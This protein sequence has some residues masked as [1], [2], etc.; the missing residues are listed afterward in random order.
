MVV[1]R[2]MEVQQKK[3]TMSF[4]QLDGVLRTVDKDGNRQSLSHKCSELDRQIPLLLGVSKSIL[5]HVVFC[6]QE[7]S[8][9]PLQEGAV[10]KKRFDDIFDSTRYSKAL[11]VFAKLKKE[12]N[13]KAKDLKADVASFGSHRHAA[14]GFRQEIEKYNCQLEELEDQI[15][16][17]KQAIKENEEE[18]ERIKAII[19]KCEDINND[20]ESR[21]NDLTL[22]QQLIKRQKT[23]LI[24]DLTKEKTAR[25]LQE[26]L[27]DFD[28][29]TNI[30]DEKKGELEAEI[31]N[32][33]NELSRLRKQE[34]DLQSKLV[35]LQAGK[36]SHQK[37]LKVRFEKMMDIGQNYGLGDVLTPISQ[38]Q[39]SQ[40]Q[41]TSCPGS[42]LADLSM[43]S[44]EQQPIL[45][46]SKEDMDEFYRALDKRERELKEAID[47]EREKRQRQEDEITD[48]ITDLNGKVRSMEKDSSKM[49]KEVIACRAEL[50]TI[51][52][53]TTVANR[54]RKADVEEAR[55]TAEKF[56]KEREIINSDPRRT[57]I[58][59]KLRSCEQKIDLLKREI[60]DDEM[61][62]KDLR[63]SA[64]SQNSVAVL[65]EQCTKDFE[66]LQESIQEQQ[67]NFNKFNISVPRELP[68]VLGDEDGAEL[69]EAVGKI[70]NDVTSKF[71][72]SKLELGS[73][74]G[75]VALLQN[76]LSESSA[77]LSH[78]RRALY[79]KRARMGQLDG[80]N[81]GISEIRSVSSNLRKYEATLGITT[82]HTIDE[83]RPQ[84]LSTYLSKRLAEEEAKST[85]GIEPETVRK[86]LTRLKSQTKQ[87]GKKVACPCC[88]REFASEPEIVAFQN[89]MKFLLAA[90]SPLLKLDERNKSARLNYKQWQQIVAN[91]INDIFEYQRITNEVD[92][93]EKN[94]EKLED[95]LSTTK[96]ELDA[97]KGA[98]ADLS[99]EVDDLRELMES[100]NKFSDAAG[101]IFE[102]RLQVNEKQL[103]LSANNADMG[104]RDLETV[105]RELTARRKQKDDHSNEVSRLN[106]E[107]STLNNRINNVSIQAQRME[108]LARE[109][110]EKFAKDQE[111]AE[112][113]IVLNN[114][115][116]SFVTEDRKL[117]EDIAP[118]RNKMRK[119]EEE[120]KTMRKLSLEEE[121]RAS[122]TFNS[123]VAAVKGLKE[124]AI[125]IDEYQDSSNEAELNEVSEVQ[126]GIAKKVQGEH[127]QIESLQPDLDRLA[128]AVEDQERHK[129]DLRENLEIIVSRQRIDEL[130][131][132][133]SELEET[134]S[135]VEGHATCYDDL[136]RI[137]SRN[138]TRLSSM[139]RLDGRRGE[140]IESIRGLK[141]KL[142]A[143]E[144][145]NVEEEYRVAMIKQETTK[146][147]VRDL[148][149]YHS[150][151]DKALLRFHGLKIA[152]I[153]TIIRDLWNL[154]YKGEDITC[155]ELVSGQD[156]GSRS[157][158]S[159]NY[160]VVMTKGST[161]LDMRGR[162]SAGQ[163]VLA[164]IVIRL[165]LA[166]TFCVNCG[167]IALDE[168]TVNLDY[169]NK[170]G[171]A[172]ALAQIIASRAQQSNFQL[173]LITHDEDFV[174]MM[175]TEL[176]TQTGFAMPEKYF[177]VRREE[178]ADGKYYSKIDAIDWDELL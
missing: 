29:Q 70:V 135:N 126:E 174:A 101:R 48:Q 176:S 19:E 160:R 123:F 103:D 89:Q 21:K 122:D 163:R 132:Q 113:K 142:S 63:R 129:K 9:W 79:T 26:M 83:T 36:E 87:I 16:E 162:C 52:Q 93:I 82:P 145:K 25:E 27:R 158:R 110:E 166:E 118:I 5:E 115:I 127:R 10:L 165:A 30:Q 81:G 116:D 14:K 95:L 124:L 59:I 172:I 2:S 75:R 28:A 86:I 92:E 128:K 12:Y 90:H 120:K 149:K 11:E 4:K 78:D 175:K 125:Q 161:Q 72:A 102:K 136:Q 6:H 24:E 34:T 96:Q 31:E 177:Q 108:K 42:S 169:S 61:A 138:Q 74:S 134:A 1:V 130:K 146:M 33:K 119:K 64:E 171:L 105:E 137:A 50:K 55:K 62:L 13:L 151:L 114:K 40:T 104:G 112:R 91:N 143:S 32:H 20:I 106:K 109:K 147:A 140:I 65:L 88:T 67:Y 100:S 44:G 47:E 3:T 157:S 38:T 66:I 117:K 43:T 107:M 167:C 8:S 98:E 37:N 111:L 54:M 148:E 139:A 71:E 17:D 159:Y 164:S 77:L 168:P 133:I 154:T 18:Q 15:A 60:E 173:I 152:E 73:T 144:Y 121:G 178:G 35:R 68:G 170:K 99:T 57:E 153:N 97:E 58:P 56:A 39:F 84:D 51:G 85:E 94:I 41:E 150:A 53:Q 76:K 45:N 69:T 80:D 155:I 46:I 49:K 7:D 131:K 156:S 22:Q 23:M 141:R